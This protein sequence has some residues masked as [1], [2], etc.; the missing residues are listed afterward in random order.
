MPT[1]LQL[2][3][4]P[5]LV[6]LS[7]IAARRWDER[8]GGL[9][10][11]FPAIAGPVLLIDAYEHGT[12]FAARAATGTV[13]GVLSLSAFAVAYGRVATG[14]SWRSSLAA[15]W[16]AAVVATVAATGTR[17]GL[18]MAALA[19]GSSLVLAHRALGSAAPARVPLADGSDVPLRMAVTAGLVLA[20]AAVAG[21]VGPEVGGI[22]TGLP[23]LASVLAVFVHRRQGAAAVTAL[24]RGMV[25]GMAGFTLFCALIGLLVDRAGVSA[26]FAVATV[27]ALGVHGTALLAG[28]GPAPSAVAPARR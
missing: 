15:G 13:L 7:T 3:I 17:A 5:A 25:A 16:A 9:V 4:G 8:A 14:R 10:S 20:L 23:V 24:L 1:V 2:L 28:A 27:A 12:A 19:A 21:L 6:A 26:A 11:A 22:L 18:A